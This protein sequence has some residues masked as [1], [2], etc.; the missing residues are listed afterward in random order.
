[1]IVMDSMGCL[2]DLEY[3]ANQREH[4]VNDSDGH[5]G[6]FCDLEYILNQRENDNHG[7]G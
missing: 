4:A 2:A 6:R 1:M 5:H 7:D 3:I